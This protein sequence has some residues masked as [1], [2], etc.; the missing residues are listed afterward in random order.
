[1]TFKKYL[2]CVFLE[3]N[4]IFILFLDLILESKNE[5]HNIFV[6]R[7]QKSSWVVHLT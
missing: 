5:I 7:Y 6:I 4:V 3:I 2:F 1:M